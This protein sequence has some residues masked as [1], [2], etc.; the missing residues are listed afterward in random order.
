MNPHETKDIDIQSR[1]QMVLTNVREVMDEMYSGELGHD[2]S[3]KESPLPLEVFDQTLDYD[4]D[5][6]AEFKGPPIIVRVPGQMMPLEPEFAK[7]L[8]EKFEAVGFSVRRVKER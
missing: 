4:E 6:L 3:G 5:E 1:L 2:F 7:Y 8:T